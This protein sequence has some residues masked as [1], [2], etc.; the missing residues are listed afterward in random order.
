MQN[1]NLLQNYFFDTIY[2]TVKGRLLLSKSRKST[3][4]QKR[5]CS[6]CTCKTLQFLIQ[7]VLSWFAL[8]SPRCEF[9][10]SSIWSSFVNIWTSHLPGTAKMV[11]CLW[12]SF[13]GA[14]LKPDHVL[15]LPQLL[16]S[17]FAFVGRGLFGSQLRYRLSWRVCL[18]NRRQKSI[19]GRYQ[20]SKQ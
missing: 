8:T 4:M 5:S 7:V 12:S 20:L 13:V 19:K 11:S 9:N 17:K 3:I 14:H 2:K 18:L 6:Q 10:M 16:L 15:T 1:Y